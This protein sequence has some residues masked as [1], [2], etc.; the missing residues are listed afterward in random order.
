MLSVEGVAN[1]QGVMHIFMKDEAKRTSEHWL[2]F[3]K[4]QQLVDP[5]GQERQF[6]SAHR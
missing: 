5:L 2:Y 4:L 3:V 1:I 6:L